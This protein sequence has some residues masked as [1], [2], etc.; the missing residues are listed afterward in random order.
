MKK[1]LL[2]SLIGFALIG[3]GGKEVT[4]DMLIGDWKCKGSEQTAKWKNGLFQDY[5]PTVDH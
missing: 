4:E 2:I 5:L 1:F 3:C